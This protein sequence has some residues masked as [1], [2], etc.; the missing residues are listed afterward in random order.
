ME[1]DTAIWGIEY[2]Y[3]GF[4]GKK[5]VPDLALEALLFGRASAGTLLYQSIL[6]GTV[7]QRLAMEVNRYSKSS[8]L[9]GACQT[10]H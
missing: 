3:L 9:G 1:A 10:P 5:G 7:R 2:L 8:T 6:R 4:L